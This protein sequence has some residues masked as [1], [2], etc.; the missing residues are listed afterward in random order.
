MLLQ[1][2]YNR[3]DI[4]W[5]INLD[6]MKLPIFLTLAFAAS[7]TTAADLTG[8]W[9]SEFDS[10][11][12]MQ[13][14]TYTFK[15]YGTNLTGKAHSEINDQ[16]RDTELKEGRV[17]G[18]DVSFVENLNFQ[19]NNIRITY[20]GKLT[21]NADEIK[22]TRQVGDFATEEIIAKREPAKSADAATASPEP[23][24]RRPGGQPIVLG[25]DDKPAFP[26]APEGFDKAREG[27]AHG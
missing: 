24:A 19:D 15:Q 21:T 6:Q 10:Q 18:N 12:G 3:L 7:F 14:Y 9:K 23:G 17:V 25:P 8:T 26:H 13:K 5:S 11:I 1:I 16:K 22:F 20:T 2:L 27:I 4:E